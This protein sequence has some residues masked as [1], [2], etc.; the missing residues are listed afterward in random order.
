MKT[1]CNIII[2]SLISLLSIINLSGCSSLMSSRMPKEG[3][4]ME[5]AYDNAMNGTDDADDSSDLQ[6]IRSEINASEQS[7]TPNYTGY[8]RTQANEINA[9][10]PRLSNPTIVMYVYPHEAGTDNNVTPVPGYST[11]FPLYQQVH[12][13]MPGES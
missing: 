5:Q 11:V 8:T 13:V 4:S 6:R 9:Q 10:F 3:A 12:Y 1:H 2:V 7:P